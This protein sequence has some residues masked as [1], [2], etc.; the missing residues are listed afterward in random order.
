MFVW[1]CRHTR[2][3]PMF[4]PEPT[5]RLQKFTRWDSFSAS[6]ARE[7]T[8]IDWGHLNVYIFPPREAGYWDVG[9]NTQIPRWWRTAKAEEVCC[10]FFSSVRPLG[11]ETA[12]CLLSSHPLC[13]LQW[14]A[15]A[16]KVMSPSLFTSWLKIWISWATTWDHQAR[17]TGLRSDGG[18]K[19]E[20]RVSC[21]LLWMETLLEIHSECFTVFLLL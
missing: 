7:S 9:P 13:T 2:I 4:V 17:G 18:W 19:Q 11:M 14:R 16:P 12:P 1:F 20:N 8:Q 21:L 3:I 10:C 5:W 6:A 15:S